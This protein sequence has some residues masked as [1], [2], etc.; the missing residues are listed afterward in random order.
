L[1]V[2][3]HSD[4][5]GNMDIYIVNADGSGMQR[6]TTDAEFDGFPTWYTP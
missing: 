1:H 6:L 4:R 5:D 3:F 2:A